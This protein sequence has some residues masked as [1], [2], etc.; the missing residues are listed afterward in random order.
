MKTK[1]QHTP[2]PWKVK[3]CVLPGG[4]GRRTNKYGPIQVWPNSEN[5]QA[6]APICQIIPQDD[7]EESRENARLIAAAPEL[8]AALIKLEAMARFHES[9][10]MQQ[11]A[12][13][14]ISK[15]GWR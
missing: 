3:A 14:A 9:K 4:Y 12:C 5:Q 15:A 7:G 6:H 10:A 13:A 8:L 1:T 11:V 2:G